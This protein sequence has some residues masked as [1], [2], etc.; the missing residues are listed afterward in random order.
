MP[1][2]RYTYLVL[3]CCVIISCKSIQRSANPEEWTDDQVNE[4]YMKREWLGSTE[5]Q[6]D[7]SINKKEFAVR[8]HQQKERWDKA[9][10]YLKNE[11]LSALA[12]G[13]HEI[14]GRDV[15]VLITQYNS[16]N[17]EDTKY[18]GHEKYT[19]IHYVVSGTEYIGVQ[20]LSASKVMTPYNAERDITFYETSKGVHLLGKPGIFFIFFP[21]NL[22]SPGMKVENNIP[23]KKAVIKVKN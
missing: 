20:D 19:D 12:A 11:D 16:K 6:P 4:W 10:N 3:L 5:L 14:E 15:Y 23:V 2:R 8:Y 7:P 18:E 9:F 21:N 1:I 17:H 22:H 13:I